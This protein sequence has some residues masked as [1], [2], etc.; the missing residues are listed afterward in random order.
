MLGVVERTVLRKVKAYRERGEASFGHG[1]KGRA[2]A[3]KV[4]LGRS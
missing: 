4:D 3:N 2:P 1:N